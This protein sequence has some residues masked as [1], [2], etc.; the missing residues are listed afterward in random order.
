MLPG[1]VPGK[2]FAFE[3]TVT[4]DMRP[5]FD[6][7][8]V[9]PVLSTWEVVHHLE[10]AGRRLLVPHLE[11]HE[12]GM[13]THIHIDHRSPAVVGSVVAFH[14]VVEE[15]TERRLVCR[16]AALVGKRIVAEGMFTQVILPRDKLAE[17]LRR[18]RRDTP[19]L[20]P[21]AEG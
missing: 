6:G 17:I 15:C 16:V 5:H 21:D 19:D 14:A 7:V 13:G 9:H 11:P 3:I 4:D 12:E 1:L 18:A 20:H 2:R 8:H 10:V